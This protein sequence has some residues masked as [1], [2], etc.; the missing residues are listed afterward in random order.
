MGGS[1]ADRNL[2]RVLV[3]SGVL[4]ILLGTVALS[5]RLPGPPGASGGILGATTGATGGPPSPPPD[6]AADRRVKVCG[7]SLCLGDQSWFLYGASVYEATHPPL[8]GIDNPDATVALAAKA[9]L[10][11]IRLVNF[12]DSNHG[13]AAREPFSEE[14]WK[15]VDV[16]IAR[17]ATA[18]MH[19]L[20]DLSDYR[21]ILWNSCIDPYAADWRRL[22]EFV[23]TRRNTVTGEVYGG[24]PAIALVG[25]AGEPQK[26]GRYDYTARVTGKPCTLT[27][28]GEEL[29]DFYRRT[30]G[31]WAA[32][33][34]WVPAHT[35]GLGYL[36][37]NSGIDWKAIFSLSENAVCGIKTYGGMI[38]FLSTGAAFC[39]ELGKP[40]VDEEFGWQ[41]TMPDDQ[42]ARLF[43]QT[44]DRL[45]RSGA[46]GAAFWNLG[47]E[48]KPE[49]Y[50]VNP[51]TPRAFAAVQEASP[52]P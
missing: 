41:Q 29:T 15:K 48:M 51:D 38:D 6:P 25:L 4:L 52:G 35:G 46:A 39:H 23:A 14:A 7:Q 9:R 18:K 34:Q 10:N 8:S 45:H 5:G 40:L 36:N 16:M 24:D 32:T 1:W 21:N 27:Y 50:E 31:Q 26:P 12:Y 13:D 2:G 47:Y 33:A 44:F 19:V 11:T 43:S 42:R 20:L 30:L 3:A 22:I 17:A 37:F 28:S 49:S